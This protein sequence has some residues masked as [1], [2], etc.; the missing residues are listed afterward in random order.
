MANGTDELAIDQ[1]V[2]QEA[3]GVGESRRLLIWA[4]MDLLAGTEVSTTR[5]LAAWIALGIT[6]L[7]AVL[8]LLGY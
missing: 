5:R 4:Q 1:P 6:F 2:N 3:I 7:M 8:L